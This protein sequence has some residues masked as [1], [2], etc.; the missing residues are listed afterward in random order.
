MYQTSSN[1][2]QIFI[3]ATTQVV[4]RNREGSAH[5]HDPPRGTF[6]FNAQPNTGDSFSITSSINFIAGTNFVIGGTILETVTNMV[7]AINALHM[8][9]LAIINS[10][11]IV[12][13]YNNSL[14][15]TL[16]IT[17]GG[18]ENIISELMQGSNISIEPNQPGPYIY[19][20]TQPFSV[21]SA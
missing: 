6:T 16:T 14:S 5:L 4:V 18:S 9:L 12:L 15:N 11:N 2:L 13:I 19:D 8:G 7:N 20:T 21:C 10:N 1:V 17:Y 3:P